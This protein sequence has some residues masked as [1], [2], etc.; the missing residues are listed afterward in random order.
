MAAAP[1]PQ[2]RPRLAGAPLPQ[3]RLPPPLPPARR[4]RRAAKRGARA[5][6]GGGGVCRAGVR[7]RAA[8][9]PGPLGARAASPAKREPGRGRRSGGNKRRRRRRR[10]VHGGGSAG[11]VP[12]PGGR[13]RRRTLERAGSGGGW[14]GPSRGRAKAAAER[15]RC[16]P[17]LR[18]FGA[19]ERWQRLHFLLHFHPW[20]EEKEGAIPTTPPPLAC[21]AK[22]KKRRARRG[23]HPAP[24]ALHVRTRIPGPG[25]PALQTFHFLCAERP[26]PSPSR[27]CTSP[28]PYLYTPPRS[29]APPASC[30]P[31]P[32][33]SSAN[34]G[35]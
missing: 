17:G 1:S 24:P 22:K 18:V 12:E 20:G 6:G 19:E 28:L 30:P 21:K 25:R 10:G 34:A 32:F 4:R 35:F 16:G 31:S 5:R 7:A 29:S 15:R 8:A 26:P 27:G 23:G 33:P 14:V 11:L 2:T 13:W 3:T 9:F